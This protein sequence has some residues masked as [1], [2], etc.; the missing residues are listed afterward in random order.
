MLGGLNRAALRRKYRDIEDLYRQ[1][2][3]GAGINPDEE[4]PVPEST[5]EPEP[6]PTPAAPAEDPFLVTE[7]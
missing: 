3:L 6:E 2:C 7:D 5:P 1:A 4:T